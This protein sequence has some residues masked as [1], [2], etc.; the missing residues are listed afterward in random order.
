[1]DTLA[2]LSHQQAEVES[3]HHNHKLALI[4]YYTYHNTDKELRAQ[5]NSAI[6]QRYTKALQQGLVGLNNRTTIDLLQHLYLNY[7][8]VTPHM[9][10]QVDLHMCQA[11]NPAQPIEDFFGQFDTAQDMCMAGGNP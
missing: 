4:Q 11:L 5:V 7:G 10:M 6:E 2:W 1:M 3:V 8:Q 9:M